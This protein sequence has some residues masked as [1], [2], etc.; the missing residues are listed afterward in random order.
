M[1]G[2]EFA[3]LLMGFFSRH[4]YFEI[5]RKRPRTDKDYRAS[6]V[7]CVYRK[8]MSLDIAFPPLYP[9]RSTLRGFTC[10]LYYDHRQL[11]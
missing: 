5:F 2:E 3:F 7:G 9:H 10:S 1:L 4:C 8:G 11:R 6:A